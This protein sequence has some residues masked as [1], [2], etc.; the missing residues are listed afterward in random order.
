MVTLSNQPNNYIH[1]L[2]MR[3]GQIAI[4]RQWIANSYIGD[5]VQ[6]VGNQLIVIGKPWGN[7]FPDIFNVKQCNLPNCLVQTLSDGATLTITN[8]Q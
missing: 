4:I 8:N 7:S 5:I 1:V 2:A 3:D 6:R